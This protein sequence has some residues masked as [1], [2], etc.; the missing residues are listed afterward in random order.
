MV[1]DQ[2]WLQN[3]TLKSDPQNYHSQPMRLIKI[4]NYRY[5][6]SVDNYF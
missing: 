1:I 2:Y 4:V 3:I 6:F 5:M